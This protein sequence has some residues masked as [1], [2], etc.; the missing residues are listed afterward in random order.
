VRYEALVAV[1]DR[2]RGKG[3]K[4]VFAERSKLPSE[5][6]W[7]FEK[8]PG[9][10]PDHPGIQGVAKAI[11]ADT[12]QHATDGV[13]AWLRQNFKYEGGGDQGGKASFERKFAVCTGHANLAASLF[14]AAGLPC[15]V[16]GCLMGARLQEHYI[17]ELWAPGEGWR[18]V[19]ATTKAFPIADSMHLVLHVAHPNFNRGAA[20]VPLHYRAAEGCTAHLKMGADQCWQG[21]TKTGSVDLAI[22]DATLLEGAARDAFRK[23]EKAPA[24]GDSMR[25]VDADSA[26]KLSARAELVSAWLDQFLGKK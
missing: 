6:A 16:L 25:L 24:R 11:K 2:P 3:E 17:V 13:L 15:R 7:F 18:R 12:L 26:K 10:D 14:Q 1:R 23:W 9:I 22:E 19:E 8:T 4:A 20:N 21:M 5:V